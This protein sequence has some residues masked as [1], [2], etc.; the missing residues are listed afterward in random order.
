MPAICG[1]SG[2]AEANDRHSAYSFRW[3]RIAYRWHPLFDRTLQVSRN[4]RG[5]ELTCIYTEERLDLARELP[6]WMFERPI[7]QA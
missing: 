1:S 5:K 2:D 6:N 3:A 7:A 4:R